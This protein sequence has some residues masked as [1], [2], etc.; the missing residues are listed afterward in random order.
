MTSL[1]NIL[2]SKEFNNI[3]IEEIEKLKIFKNI[4]LN[5]II[6]WKIPYQMLDS[7]GNKI[8]NDNSEKLRGN[9]K[10]IPPNNWYGI[11]LKVNEKYDNGNDIWLGKNNKN[12]E[13]WVAYHGLGSRLGLDGLDK[14]NLIINS[15]LR[16]NLKPGPG[17]A[18]SFCDD[19]F[20]KGKKVG[21]G[22]GLTPD[23][24]LAEGYAGKIDINGDFYKVVLMLRVK[25]DKIRACSCG[26]IWTLNGSYDEIRPYRILFKRC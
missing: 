18:H 23:I 5:V 19:I 9:I 1:D 14:I 3:N 12:G 26:D 25:P 13:W 6:N 22:V 8:F 17:Q 15:V 21:I 24:W 11:G 20:H 16:S 7:K 4:Q 10:Y 2:Q